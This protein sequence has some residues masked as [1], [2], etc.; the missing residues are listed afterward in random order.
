M[1][2]IEINF[3]TGLVPVPR[4]FTLYSHDLPTP[5]VNDN[6]HAHTSRL[7]KHTADQDVTSLVKVNNLSCSDKNK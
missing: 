3:K 7:L 2:Y 4:T 6:I 1:V 5:V